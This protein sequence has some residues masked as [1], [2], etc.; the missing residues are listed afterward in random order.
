[1]SR[2]RR[3]H[4][5]IWLLLALAMALTSAC[6]ET[7]AA[8]RSTSRTSQ[9]AGFDRALHDSLPS[10]VQK[11]GT[12]TVGTDASYAPMSSFG[13]DGRTIVGMEPDL[14][15][16]LGVVLGVRVRFGDTDFTDLLPS[17]VHGSLDLGMSAM[18]DTAARARTVDFVNYF[19]AGTAILVQRGNPSGI[20]DLQSLC[21]HIVAVEAGTTQVDLLHRA[22]SNCTGRRII[23][24]TYGTNSDAL[25]QLRTGRAGAVLNDLP[26]AIFLV[27]DPR[28]RSHFQLASSA[29]YEPGLYGI[30]VAK[31]Q[32]ALRD[33]VRGALDRLLDSGDYA[34]AL[35]T[36]HVNDGAVDRV[37]VNSDR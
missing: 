21:G 18:T 3:V 35:K 10:S 17:V 4:P 19:S 20:S 13:S 32:S 2:R 22:Q 11:R 1:M 31:D 29:Q 9:H 12:L 5:V 34:D 6:G 33:A 26:P 16:A 25:L 28:T 15:R 30:A 14:G 8:D 27:N 37:S 23:V 36:W 24:K 7:A